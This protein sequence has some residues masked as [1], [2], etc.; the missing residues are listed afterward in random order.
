M[1]EG[2]VQI[3]GNFIRKN[4]IISL[5]IEKNEVYDDD[6]DFISS[7]NLRPADL[8]IIINKADEYCIPDD[9]IDSWFTFI[10]SWFNITDYNEVTSKSVELCRLAKSRGRKDINEDLNI[11]Y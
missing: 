10:K 8:F 7:D 3:N 11:N 1:L 2:F 5:V 6:P 4:E 9:D